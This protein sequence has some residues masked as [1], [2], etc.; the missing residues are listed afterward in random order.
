MER[1]ASRLGVA[2]GRLTSYPLST[3]LRNVEV[4]SDQLS[5]LIHVYLTK[6]VVSERSMGDDVIKQESLL[7]DIANA[8]CHPGGLASFVQ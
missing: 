1:Q 6:E 4:R 7:H 5:P 3:Q 8:V 2:I